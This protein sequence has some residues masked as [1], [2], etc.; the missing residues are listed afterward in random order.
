MLT[1]LYLGALQLVKISQIIIHKF[2][3]DSFS[4]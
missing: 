2:T 4:S 1:N 3:E